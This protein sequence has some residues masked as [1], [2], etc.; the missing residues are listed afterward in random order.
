MM[1]IDGKAFISG[2]CVLVHT[3]GA[4]IV[5]VSIG[6]DRDDLVFITEAASQSSSLRFHDRVGN[7]HIVWFNCGWVAVTISHR[8][9]CYHEFYS[10]L[11]YGK[12]QFIFLT[13]THHTAH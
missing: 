8:L 12:Y 10:N 11:R 1:T 2:E 5:V 13:P 6:I 7:I 9:F 3:E 4:R